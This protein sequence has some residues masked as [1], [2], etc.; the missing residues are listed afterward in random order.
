M[1]PQSIDKSKQEEV[2]RKGPKDKGSKK[3]IPLIYLLGGGLFILLLFVGTILSFL[4]SQKS[5]EESKTPILRG[6]ELKEDPRKIITPSRSEQYAS[7]IKNRKRNEKK[8]AIEKDRM[9]RIAM[10]WEEIYK[11]ATEESEAAG[12]GEK[13]LIPSDVE[14]ES[15]GDKNSSPPSFKKRPNRRDTR[16]AAKGKSKSDKKASDWTHDIYKDDAT[17]KNQILERRE[18][19]SW[20]ESPTFNT[21]EK[22]NLEAKKIPIA[23]VGGIIDGDQRIRAGQYIK[24]RLSENLA[25]PGGEVLPINTSLM[26][27]CSFGDSRIKAEVGAIYFKGELLP[28]T[29]KLFDVDLIEGIAYHDPRIKAQEQREIESAG[30]EL[31]DDI[32]YEIPYAGAFLNAGK[33]ILKNRSREKSRKVSLPNNYRVNFQV[34]HK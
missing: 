32:L 14:K 6:P 5:L 22:R 34:Y 2:N 20:E 25:L 31:Y 27:L 1:A 17:Q 26:G 30:S 13:L 28:I 9:N 18:R 24:F 7:D 21:L 15:E 4:L 29:L 12:R 23:R 8:E 10:R 3:K 16:N 11:G 33:N 19:N